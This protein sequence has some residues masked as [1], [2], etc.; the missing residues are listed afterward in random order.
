MAK[1]G[2]PTA[3]VRR[4][5]GELVVDDPDACAI[6]RVVQKH[7]CRVTLDLNADRIAYFKHRLS[8]R[9]LTAA[10]AVIVILNVDDPNG[11]VLAEVLMP[12]HNWQEYRDRGE[13]PFARGLAMRDGIQKALGVIDK[14][15]AEK[16]EEMTDVA[17][18]VVVVDCGVAEIFPA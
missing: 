4:V 1:R 16:L 12:G 15:A 17:V 7:N 5:N 6:F 3:V 2:Y 9:G 8:E 18:A 14:D 10:Q 13:V 11:A